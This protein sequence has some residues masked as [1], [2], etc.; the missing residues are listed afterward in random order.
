MAD[1]EQPWWETE[2]KKIGWTKVN[3]NKIKPGALV[4]ILTNAHPQ[5]VRE[6]EFVEYDENSYPTNSPIINYKYKG[7][8]YSS[9]IHHATTK[10]K[11][12]IKESISRFN[13]RLKYLVSESQEVCEILAELEKELKEYT[14]KKK[15]ETYESNLKILRKENNV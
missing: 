9:S 4:F 7:K 11:H 14:D 13:N 3:W 2:W 10:K 8:I 6:G 5:I 12:A 15:L 1:K